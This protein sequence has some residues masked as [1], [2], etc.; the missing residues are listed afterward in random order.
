MPMK[1]LLL[2]VS[3]A[4]ILVLSIPST[5][6]AHNT[7]TGIVTDCNG[8]PLPG[9]LVYTAAE[10][11]TD[12]CSNWLN[13]RVACRTTDASG[14]YEQLWDPNPTAIHWCIGV[15]PDGAGDGYGGCTGTQILC[16]N[17][18]EPAVT[19]GSF[20][21]AASV[22]N[23]TFTK[24]IQVNYSPPCVTGV[25]DQDGGRASL[26]PCSPNPF[27]N[28]TTAELHL[29]RPGLVKVT[30]FDTQGRRVKRLLDGYQIAQRLLVTWDGR[31]DGGVM[32]SPGIY[33]LRMVAEGQVLRTTTAL[34]R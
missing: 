20:N 1:A 14:R 5:G 33:S 31:N 24:D 34:V 28:S 26:G 11:I 21:S 7:N 25:S 8:N 30:V 32:A 27:R 3:V 2:L 13:H 12:N 23:T 17:G 4:A 22:D 16:C 18:N 6:M 19:I 29:N 15:I 10:L 9:V